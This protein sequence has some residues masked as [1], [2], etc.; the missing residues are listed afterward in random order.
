MFCPK[1]VV[2]FITVPNFGTTSV[3]GRLEH[4]F[5]FKDFNVD[6]LL[7]IMI[8]TPIMGIIKNC[9]V[10]PHN[11]QL[12]RNYEDVW[13]KLNVYDYTYQP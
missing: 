4:T 9:F 12:H 2:F 11:Y 13:T 5:N 3:F 10:I 6:H 8:F 7:P 1:V